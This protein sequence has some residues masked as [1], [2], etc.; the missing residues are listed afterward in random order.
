MEF[1][2][3]IGLE[4]HVQ[5]NTKTKIFCSCATSFGESPNKNVCPTCLALPGALPVLNRE[6][7]KKAIQFGTA[8]NAQINQN[9]IFARKNYFYPDLPKAYQISQY[10]IPIVGRG[11]IEIEM[12]SESDGATHK[13]IGVTRAHLEEDA[14]KNIHEGTHSKVDLN[15]ACTPLLE[16]VSEPDMRSADEAVAYLK[17]LHSIVRFLGISDA[18]MQEGSFRCDANVSIRPRGDSSLYTRVEIKNL[19]SFRFIQKAIEYEVQRQREA[20]GD[21]SYERGVVQETRLF[22]TQKGVTRSMRGKEEAADYRYF[23]DPDLLPVFIDENLMRDGQQIA[24]MPD[25][26]RARYINDFGLK[27]KDAAMLTNELELAQYFESMIENGASGKGAFVWLGNELLGRLKGEN[28]L[29]TCG[30]DSTTLAILVKRVESSAISGK[31]GKDILD[32]LVEKRGI[33]ENGAKLE[34]DSLIE[35]LG[36]AQVND[37]SAILVAIE[38][39]LS[40]NADKVAEYKNGKDKLFGFFV[41]QVMKNAKGVNPARVN[42]LLKEKLNA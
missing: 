20:W 38:A 30:V 12:D 35:S 36:L 7:V 16:I 18:N 21:G 22:D 39:V 33:D 25:E 32:V 31:S 4:V 24:E 1:E 37:D 9:S 42:E 28:T 13:T 29:Q 27:P 14:G 17:K 41:G 3:I 26:K 23:P 15:R 34:I 5:L 19:N 40:A 2:T 6:A 10:E 8:I 11:T